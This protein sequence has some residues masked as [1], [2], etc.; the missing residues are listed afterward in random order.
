MQT[1]RTYWAGLNNGL[2]SA[3]IGMGMVLVGIFGI[4]G[5]ASESAKPAPTMTQDQV[6][7]NTDKAF[8]RLKQEEK[9][10]ALD[11]GGAPY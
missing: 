7:G 4:Y 2:I 10:R 8:E 9:H 6:R 5:C 11:S 1:N 3:A